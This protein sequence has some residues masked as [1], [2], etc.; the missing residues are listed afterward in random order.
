MNS[1]EFVAARLRHLCRREDPAF[2]ES[3]PAYAKCLRQ[4]QEM[5][6]PA[7]P[8]EFGRVGRDR[9][10]CGVR[11]GSKGRY[12]VLRIS[13]LIFPRRSPGRT[14]RAGRARD[15]GSSH[16]ER[17]LHPGGTGFERAPDDPTRVL[18]LVT[19]TPTRFRMVSIARW[20]IILEES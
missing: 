12:H 6:A 15:R 17:G 2:S 20:I 13:E 3:K 10:P 4:E 16:C 9:A 18:M 14:A 1:V 19:V 11:S 5:H 7:L 8:K